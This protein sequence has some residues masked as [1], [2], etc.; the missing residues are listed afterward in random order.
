MSLTPHG[1]GFSFVDQFEII[2]SQKSGR[3]TKW[4]DPK[5]SFFK[6]HFPG[7]PLMPGVL[8]IEC[9]AQAA[10][11]LWQSGKDGSSELRLVQ[12]NQ[13]RFKQ[14]VLPGQT[15]RIEVILEKDFGS[16]AQFQSILSVDDV[17]V[18]A[19]NIML[20]KVV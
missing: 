5:S 4:L 10:G 6:D 12:V 20:G 9:A 14:A 15:L 16:L 18:A 8:L 11:C 3:G 19:G 1:P 2:E 7:N 17:E 13:F